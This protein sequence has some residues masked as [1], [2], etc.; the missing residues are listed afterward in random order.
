M[1]KRRSP[2]IRV[3]HHTA[4]PVPGTAALRVPAAAV[5]VRGQ[6]EIVFVVEDGLA[7]LRLVKTGKRLGNE[8]ELLSGV[9]EGERVV[10]Q[11]VDRVLD[12]QPVDVQ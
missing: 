3:S 8:V 7:K 6:M 1:P 9:D 12:G 4:V 11:G 2:L 10:T 5:R